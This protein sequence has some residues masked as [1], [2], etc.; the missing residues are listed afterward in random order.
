MTFVLLMKT[1]MAKPKPLDS[2]TSAT[3]LNGCPGILILIKNPYCRLQ[4]TKLSRNNWVKYIQVCQEASLS[5][6]YSI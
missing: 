3:T 5:I 2:E 1:L 4:L 6:I